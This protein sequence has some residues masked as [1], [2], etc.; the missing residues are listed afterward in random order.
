MQVFG[1]FGT[2]VLVQNYGLQVW[3]ISLLLLVSGVVNFFIV[4]LLGR[5]LDRFGE[6]IMLSTSY[7]ALALCFM[8]YAT[9]PQ[10]LALGV[11]LGLHQFAGHASDGALYLCE[12]HR[13]PWGIDA[14]P[15]SRREHQSFDFG[16]HV[17]AGGHPVE[18]R[19]L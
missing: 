6:R 1:A 11:S 2:L 5:L 4:P 14:D 17:A 10:C 3:E 9:F 19:W 15:L 16:E 12:P 8:G 7:V 13:S 18:H